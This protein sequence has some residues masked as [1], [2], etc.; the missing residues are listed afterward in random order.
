ML[1]LVVT[2]TEL[3]GRRISLDSAHTTIGRQ[4]G[5]GF[6]DDPTVSRRHAVIERDTNGVVLRDL[7]SSNGTAVNGVP[8]FGPV[9]LHVGDHVRFGRVETVLEPPA[10][11]LNIGS[12]GAEQINNVDGNQ[13]IQHIRQERE[14]FL[15]DIASS[16]TK[17]RRLVGFG[18]FCIVV[19]FLLFGYGVVS[20]IQGIPGITIDTPQSDMPTPFG[21]DVGGVPLGIIGFAIAAIGSFVL[22]AGIVM[23]VSAAARLRRQNY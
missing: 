19:G 21:P 16:K 11:G 10:A 18:F 20:F 17:A 22:I 3:A 5:A 15:A 13:Y 7:G 9:R 1:S 8:V 14:S 2:T 6:L 12:Q 4:D 23:H